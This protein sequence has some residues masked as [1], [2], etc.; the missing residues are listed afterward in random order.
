MRQNTLGNVR[1]KVKAALGKSW[2]TTSTQEDAVL[3]QTISDI[4]QLLSTQYS[5][6]FLKNRWDTFLNPGSRFQAFPTE[7]YN[8]LTT[9]PVY[10][11]PITCEIKWNQIWQFVV[12]GIDE[13]PE[14]NYLDSDRGQILDPIQ[15]WQFADEAQWEVWPM[16]AST[17]QVRFIGQRQLTS[18][19]T[20]STTPPTWNDAALLD[21]DDNLV[22]YHAAAQIAEQ[23]KRQQAGTLRQQAVMTLRALLGAYP[24]RDKEIQIGV[25]PPAG[26]KQ[27]R[28]VPLVLVAGSKNA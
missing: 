18:L 5:W 14:F 8:G 26:Q 2:S 19:Q 4:Q 1:Y 28:Q 9:N 13:Y 16:P 24:V 22:A 20:G 12:Y 6:P 3:N 27:I 10:E 21:L 7:D 23:E 25:E 11:R 17:S 15:R